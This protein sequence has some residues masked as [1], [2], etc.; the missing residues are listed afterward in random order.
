MR[1]LNKS[2]FVPALFVLQV[3]TLPLVGAAQTYTVTDLG[4]LGGSVS[5]AQGINAAGQITGYSFIAGGGVVSHA[6]LYSAGHMADLGTLGGNVGEGNGINSSGQIAGYA[7]NAKP[8]YR[9][10]LYSDSTM[11]DLGDLGG[12]AAVAYALN[13]AGEVVGASWLAD[14]EVHP[15]LY[16]NGQMIDLGT[17]GAHT[18]G[19]WN[20][21]QGINNSGEITGTSY[22]AAGNFLAF[23]YRN[24]QMHALGTLGGQ[25]SQAYA[26]NDSGRVTGIA[27]TQNNLTAHAFVTTSA[28]MKD[29]GVIDGG[30]A[31]WG[32]GINSHGVVVG[33]S[34]CTS[35]S[36]GYAAFVYRNGKMLDL[37]TLIQPGSGWI[38]EQANSINDAGEI[39]G[40]GTHNG[41]QHAFLLTPE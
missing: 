20:S 35:C 26:I 10:F 37:N 1:W 27:Y 24:G 31:S 13:D 8:A 39:V 36:A 3:L 25:W 23:V 18:A 14:G 12:G 22:D 19:W 34:D 41:Q 6:F 30:P 16:S 17:L 7:T 29:L 28:K 21:A 4:T 33:Q 5:G 38:L 9:A 15:F 40:Y 32:F 11:S 2:L